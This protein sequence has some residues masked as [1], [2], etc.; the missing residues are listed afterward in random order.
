MAFGGNH[1]I[2]QSTDCGVDP[3]DRG[4]R[5]RQRRDNCQNQGARDT[6]AQVDLMTIIKSFNPNNLKDGT[7]TSG[8]SSA[9][10][11]L[12]YHCS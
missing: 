12:M 8:E 6:Q 7:F 2:S 1:F 3:N 11:E 10:K 5:G 4:S 9:R